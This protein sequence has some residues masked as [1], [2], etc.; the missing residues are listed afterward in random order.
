MR[1]TNKN[2][3]SLFIIHLRKRNSLLQFLQNI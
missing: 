2:R 3:I 1:G